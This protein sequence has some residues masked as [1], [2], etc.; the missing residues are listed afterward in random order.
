MILIERKV[1]PRPLMIVTKLS[2]ITL[3]NGNYNLSRYITLHLADAFIQ[4]VSHTHTHI[5][6][7]VLFIFMYLFILCMYNIII[8]LVMF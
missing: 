3:C 5:I 6:P 1:I 4:R 8:I 7:I 2:P